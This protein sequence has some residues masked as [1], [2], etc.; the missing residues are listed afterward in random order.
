MM[1]LLVFAVALLAL[2]ACSKD[3]EINPPAELVE[4]SP[5]LKVERV[6]TSGVGDGGEELRLGL[7]LAVRGER[8]VYGAGRGGD[9]AAFELATGKQLWRTRTK[10]PLA[11]GT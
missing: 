1:R 9:V 4:I 8:V 7:G 2:G 6:W 3:K 5:T 11:A 10:A